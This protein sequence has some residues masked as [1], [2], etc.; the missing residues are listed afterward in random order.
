MK[1]NL[2][3]AIQAELS[4]WRIGALPGLLVIGLVV[5]LR[6]TGSLQPLEWWTLDYLLRSRPSELSDKRILIVGIDE[7]DIRNAKAYPIPD[8][9]LAALL[10]KL[11]THQPRAIGLDIIRDMAVEPGHAALSQ[12]LSSST[13]IIGIEKALPDDRGNII[14]APSALPPEQVGFADIIADQ[15]GALRRSLLSTWTANGDYKFS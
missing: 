10:A 11:Q 1:R 13:N 14:Q 9:Q 8:H 5:F 7:Q 15:D 4:I 3:Q 12:Q 6:L 2:W